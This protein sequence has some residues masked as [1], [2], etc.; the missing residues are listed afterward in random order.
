MSA[1]PKTIGGAAFRFQA[2]RRFQDQLNDELK[3]LLRQLQGLLATAASSRT[4]D[5]TYVIPPSSE[6]RV[7][8]EAGTLVQRFFVG[9]DLRHPYGSDGVTPLAPYPRILNQ[10]L[11]W[12]TY[13]VV[14]THTQYMKKRLPAD[15]E[16]W[17]NVRLS[18]EQF[19]QNPLAGYEAPHTW[20]DP[21]GYRLSDRI[22]QTSIE[23]RRK[24]DALI[25]D[26]IRNGRSAIDMSKDLEAFLLPNRAGLKT[27][28]PYG[29]KASFDAMRLGRSEIARAH[30]YASLAAGRANPFVDGWEWAES[31]QH[32]KFDVCDK[33]AT[34]DSTGKRVRDPYPINGNCPVVVQDSHPQCIC[35]NYTSVSQKPAD[36]I[37]QLRE[38]M[39][40]GEPAPLTPIDTFDFVKLLIGSYLT[41]IIFREIAGQQ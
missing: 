1:N 4:P 39:E 12:V 35:V 18:R 37:A 13:K 14:Q 33:L 7:L 17:L 6:N 28:K 9:S 15:I 31:L 11:A 32:P 26:G 38:Q 16:R 23:T 2:T 30:S 29:T 8:D 20:I 41:S 25:A 22:W 10:W 40:Q 24:I 19:N 34:I 27:D 3:P 5:G 21:K 36:V